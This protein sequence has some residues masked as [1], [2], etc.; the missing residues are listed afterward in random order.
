M[1]VVL[2]EILEEVLKKKL[3]AIV[4][5]VDNR[6]L[7]EAAGTTNTL[8][9]KRLMVDMSALREA[10][11]RREVE[12]EWIPTGDQLADVLTKEGADK[13]KLRR[14]MCKGVLMSG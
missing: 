9:E 6:S 1:A 3:P 11:E 7:Y 4:L 12:M 5:R 8:T 2:K 10:V 13:R 14:V